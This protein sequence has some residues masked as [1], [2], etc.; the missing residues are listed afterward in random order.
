M[1]NYYV[2]ILTNKRNGTLYVGMTNNLKRRVDEHK[3]EIIDCFPPRRTPCLL[4]NMK[5]HKN[6]HCEERS[7]EAVQ[8]HYRLLQSSRFPAG[9]LRND[10][11]VHIVLKKVYYFYLLGMTKNYF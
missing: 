8:K 2:C 5:Y 6:C 4:M 7:D 11:C 1:N 3:S 10:F 9:F